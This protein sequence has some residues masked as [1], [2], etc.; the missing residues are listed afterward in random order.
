[1]GSN[2]GQFL[3]C[4]WASGQQLTATRPKHCVKEAQLK[5]EIL[6]S[7]PLRKKR[8]DVTRFVERLER[9]II[10]I[11]VLVLTLIQ[12]YKVLVHEIH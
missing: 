11:L 10:R 1:L 9:L 4:H 8:L 3:G 2:F 7:A 6:M 5:E 12:F